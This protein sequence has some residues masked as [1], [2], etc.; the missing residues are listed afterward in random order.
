VCCGENNTEIY[1]NSE[2]R[3]AKA[4]GSVVEVTQGYGKCDNS[5]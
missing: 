2:K 5:D 4:E 1:Y 3:Y